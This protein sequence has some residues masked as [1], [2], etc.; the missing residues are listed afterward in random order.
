MSTECLNNIIKDFIEL[1]LLILNM[2]ILNTKN[3]SDSEGSGD[4]DEM[5]S[6]MVSEKSVIKM[7]E[8]AAS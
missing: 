1:N 5:V 3:Y 2:T 4:D 6:E 8:K 7:D